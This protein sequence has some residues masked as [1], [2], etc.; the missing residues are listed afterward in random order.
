MKETQTK[1]ARIGYIDFIKF[2]S[3]L[4]IMIYHYRHLATYSDDSIPIPLNNTFGLIYQYGYLVVELFFLFSGFTLS[5]SCA[6]KCSKNLREYYLPKVKRI[7]PIYLITMLISI[8]LQFFSKLATGNFVLGLKNYTLTDL[9]LSL[10][11]L[12]CGIFWTRVPF[13]VPAWFITPLLL[14]YLSFF[15]ICHLSKDK[16]AVA[17]ICYIIASG[18]VLLNQYNLP[19][20]NIRI[21][22]G[23]FS[24]FMGVVL[25][26]TYNLVNQLL[27]QKKRL[28]KFILLLFILVVIF[29]VKFNLS[30]NLYF[31]ATV[32]FFIIILFLQLSTNIKNLFQIDKIF[33]MS[34]FLSKCSL[35]IFFVHYV[36]LTAISVFSV[37]FDI[38]KFYDTWL[39]FLFYCGTV[40]IF[41][42]MLYKITNK[43]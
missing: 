9:I 14:C 12:Q 16:K 30:N 3:A 27:P 19:I 34:T 33:K 17:I 39:L 4:I 35:S 15:F 40:F 41:S 28:I 37:F 36:I 26:Y 42:F 21:A 5:I 32:F 43:Q 38:S 18:I 31:E 1:S 29:F 25:Y 22:R 24:F 13:N 7:L 6:N 8:L 23:Y 10:L 20:L 11:G 2:C